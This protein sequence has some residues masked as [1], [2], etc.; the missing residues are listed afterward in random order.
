M[1]DILRKGDELRAQGVSPEDTIREINRLVLEVAMP[2]IQELN[3]W[4][5]ESS[6]ADI[7]FGPK[8]KENEGA[9]ELSPGN[10]VIL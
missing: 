6:H 2:A 1:K 7:W 9:Q 3:D 8:P 4:A 10:E 5:E